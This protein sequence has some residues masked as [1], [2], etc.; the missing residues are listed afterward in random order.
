[1]TWKLIDYLRTQTE[2][3]RKINVRAIGPLQ[4]DQTVDTKRNYIWPKYVKIDFI[5]I[6]TFLPIATFRFLWPSIWN[7]L[8]SQMA[9]CEMSITN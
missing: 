7:Q 3:N 2:T 9:K 1:M 8:I 5:G 6:E 4:G